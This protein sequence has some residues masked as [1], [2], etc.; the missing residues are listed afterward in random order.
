MLEGHTLNEQ[1]KR[2]EPVDTLCRFCGQTHSTKMDRNY[3]VPVFKVQDRTS[4]VIY[5][6]VKFSKVSVGIPRCTRCF[7]THQENAWKSWG[8]S[9]ASAITLIILGFTIFGY[10][11]VFVARPSFVLLFVSGILLSDFLD[12]KKGLMRKKDV[13]NRDPLIQQMLIS[14]WSLTP[15]TAR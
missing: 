7:V 12:R 3:F 14:G 1:E 5:S 9:T 8:I 2:I 13:A 10:W 15:P 4:L 11:G 6:S